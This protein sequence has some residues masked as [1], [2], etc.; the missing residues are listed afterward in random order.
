M[1]KLLDS[2]CLDYILPSC[3]PLGIRFVFYSIIW[4]LC[5]FCQLNFLFHSALYLCLFPSVL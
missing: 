4:L 2:Q 5:R 3:V 1:K